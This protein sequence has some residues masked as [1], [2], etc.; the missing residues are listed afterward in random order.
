LFKLL[1]SWKKNGQILSSLG[2][3]N[4]KA[5][6]AKFLVCKIASMKRLG[7]SPRGW[8][9]SFWTLARKWVTKFGWITKFW[10]RKFQGLALS[11]LALL[12]VLRK[13]V[14]DSHFCD[15]MKILD[16]LYL[17]IIDDEI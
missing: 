6:F 17:R 3:T 11:E 7:S 14:Q 12:I 4:R 13:I 10:S 15:E 8:M 1:K 9:D 5:I 2:L 16:S